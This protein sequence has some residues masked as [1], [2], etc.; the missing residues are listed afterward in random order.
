MHRVIAHVSGKVQR[1]GYRSE[2]VTIGR[3]LDL[4]GY[5]KNL[6]DDRVEILAEGSEADLERFC[7]AIRIESTS[8]RVDDIEIG[9][10]D[11]AGGSN[12]FHEVLDIGETCIQPNMESDIVIEYLKELIEAFREGFKEMSLRLDKINSTLDKIALNYDIED[13][14]D[15]GMKAANEGPRVEGSN[16]E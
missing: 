4:T 2:V 11:L 9:Y 3:A 5:A 12:G 10:S 13:V 8:V 14:R 15:I 6:P 7:K 1:N 16:Q